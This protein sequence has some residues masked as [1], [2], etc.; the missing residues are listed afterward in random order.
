MLTNDSNDA[1]V[2][3]VDFGFATKCNGFD[4]TLQ[5][6]TI[7]YMAPGKLAVVSPRLFL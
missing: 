6:G 4:Q 3:I 5:C 1:D 7:G 2:K